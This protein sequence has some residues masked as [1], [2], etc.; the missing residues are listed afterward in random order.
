MATQ[1]V[2]SSLHVTA[3]TFSLL[4]KICTTAS[5]FYSFLR[6]S[7][8][9]YGKKWKSTVHGAPSRAGKTFAAPPARGGQKVLPTGSPRSYTYVG[10]KFSV[11]RAG[12]MG[13]EGERMRDVLAA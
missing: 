13:G 3:F 7:I 2:R 8:S 4:I 6:T 1:G 5:K 9:I 10:E 11:L 12:G